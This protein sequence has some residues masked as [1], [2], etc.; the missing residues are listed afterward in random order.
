MRQPSTPRFFLNLSIGT[1]ILFLL[2]SILLV[3]L[4]KTLPNL[5]QL[6]GRSF[7]MPSERLLQFL[8]IEIPFFRTEGVQATANHQEIEINGEKQTL[9]PF[10][11]FSNIKPEQWIKQEIPSF[12]Q[13]DHLLASNLEAGDYRMESATPEELVVHEE[14]KAEQSNNGQIPAAT[15]EKK[16]AVFIYHTHNRESFVPETKKLYG[17][18]QVIVYDEKVNI[19]LVGKKLGEELD[20]LGIGSVISDEDYYPDLEHYSLAYAHSLGTVK[21]ALQQNKDYRFVLDIHRDAPPKKDKSLTT[22]KINGK[23]YALISFVIGTGNKNYQ[24]NKQLAETINE[25]LNRLYPGISKG[26]I[27][28]PKSAG[29]NGEYNQSVSPYSLTVEIGGHYNTIE[30]EYRSAKALAE[31]IADIYWQAVKVNTIVEPSEQ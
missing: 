17:N 26:I 15:T 21:T 13:M 24:Q 25:T 29:T 5:N 22:T 10:F 9:I 8:T 31:A 6:V 11:S 1:A 3:Q 19:T 14:N 18:E 27:E 7:Q 28:K 2:V 23:D 4:P 12:S 16:N 20:K 30:D